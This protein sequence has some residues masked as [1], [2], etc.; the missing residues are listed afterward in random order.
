DDANIDMVFALIREMNDFNETAREAVKELNISISN[1]GRYDITIETEEGIIFT[2]KYN[3][4]PFFTDEI[5]IE[6]SLSKGKT[7][8]LNKFRGDIDALDEN[9]NCIVDRYY[10]SQG[11]LNS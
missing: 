7:K 6:G 10:Y 8:E 9:N 11:N 4:N 3:S 5:E 1:R 2:G